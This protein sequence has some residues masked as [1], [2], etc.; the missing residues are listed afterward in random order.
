[1]ASYYKRVFKP[2]IREYLYVIPGKK[3]F[4]GLIK[5]IWNLVK[6]N[7]VTYPVAVTVLTTHCSLKCAKCNNLMPCYKEPYHI[8][9][10]TVLKDISTLLSHT[11]ICIKL[12]LL[13][14]EPFV[15][16]EINTVIKGVREFKNVMC[17]AFTTNAT[18]IPGDE[19][20]KLIA[21][22]KNKKVVISDYGIK[23]QKVEELMEACRK[24]NIPCARSVSEYWADPGGL[25]CRGKTQEQLGIEYDKCYSSRYCRTMLNG[26]MYA[27]ARS[28]SLADLGYMDGTH[29]SF[30]IR[31]ER[32]D[33]EFRKEFRKFLTL[34]YA[35]ACNYCDHFKG[36]RIPSGEQLDGGLNA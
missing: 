15:Y 4:F 31:R 12:E 22:L 1:M 24:Y 27:C 14:G 6:P 7:A 36:I 32:S 23:T 34:D 16:P 33:K 5:L 13:G 21:S 29:D 3:T 11:D 10:Q 2:S 8:P 26:K 19:T 25:D 28:A 17:V 35:D 9:A 20:L 30:D 18:V